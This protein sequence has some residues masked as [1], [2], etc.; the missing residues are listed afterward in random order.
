MDSKRTSSQKTFYDGGQ[1]IDHAADFACSKTASIHSGRCKRRP[2]TG[3]RK[4]RR[5]R[6]LRHFES[7]EPRYSSAAFRPKIDGGRRYGGDCFR[8]EIEVIHGSSLT[9]YR[10]DGHITI[11]RE[12]RW[13]WRRFPH[14]QIHNHQWYMRPMPLQHDKIFRSRC[15]DQS[16]EGISARPRL[17]TTSPA[18][19]VRRKAVDY[20]APSNLSMMRS[21]ACCGVMV[22]VLIRI[23]GE[24]GNS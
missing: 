8:H 15:A 3:N 19:Y 23:S 16:W 24:I 17:V 5:R 2:A 1:A 13:L 4:T 22:V 18:Y 20:S 7:N 14:A 6:D 11:C 21:A 9:K 12:S 10:C